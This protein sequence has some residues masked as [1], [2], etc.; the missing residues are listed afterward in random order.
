MTT[1]EWLSRGRDISRAV[2][3]LI[4]AKVRA[5][6]MAEGATKP[7]GKVKVQG[8]GGNT[9]QDR[10]MT[11]AELS[12]EIDRQLAELFRMQAE[13][14]SELKK[15]EDLRLRA[16][17]IDRYVNNESF[18]DI[19]KKQKYSERRIYALHKKALSIFEGLKSVQ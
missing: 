19:A 15:V 12:E 8:G 16:V 3:T 7:L 10:M 5:L 17:L 4:G 11:F 14:L 9:T 2:D 18:E 1:R 13:I 6:S